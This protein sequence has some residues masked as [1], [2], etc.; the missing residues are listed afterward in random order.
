[1]NG[2]L[3]RPV[4]L[5]LLRELLTLLGINHKTTSAMA[6]SVNGEAEVFN[7]FIAQYCKTHLTDPPAEWEGCLAS[8][9]LAYNTATHSSTRQEPFTLLFGRQ[10]PQPQLDPL[11]PALQ[12]PSWP[13]QQARFLVQARED[14]NA[15]LHQAATKMMAR[16]PP[17]QPF[18]P[19]VG[20]RVL[21]HY[22][23]TALA[24]RGTPKLQQQWQPATVLEQ[25]G[26]LTY[27][28][29]PLRP[30]AHST[31]VHVQRLKPLLPRQIT[32]LVL[33]RPDPSATARAPFP[34]TAVSASALPPPLFFP[35]R[36]EQRHHAIR[37]PWCE[38]GFPCPRGHK[39]PLLPYLPSIEWP[40]VVT[41]APPPA[42]RLPLSPRDR[43][44]QH[45]A[46]RRHGPPPSTRGN[47]APPPTPI[48]RAQAPA[49]LR[50]LHTDLVEY[51]N[52]VPPPPPV[53]D[54][55]DPLA[56]R[57]H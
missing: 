46:R 11:A 49:L 41:P 27:L 44:L 7:K 20:E 26:P 56:A 17:G 16:N 39:Q 10:C 54:L 37:C 22:P 47:P 25:K 19:L 29:Q 50:R 51:P 8:L 38:F 31:V 34:L 32:P 45:I 12:E 14:A 40:P 33:P 15:A 57:P 1:M 36:G 2:V 42:P 43:L 18:A 23:R 24:A 21:L 13:A 48:P 6:P 35:A 52:P 30:G 4:T 28:V 5:G 9:N 55:R 3:T 53:G